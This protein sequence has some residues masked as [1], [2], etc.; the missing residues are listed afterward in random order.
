MKMNTMPLAT[1]AALALP[2]LTGCAGGLQ[3]NHAAD[4]LLR[5]ASYQTYGIVGHGVGQADADVRIEEAIHEA[6]TA[7]GFTH[8]KPGQVD[9]LVSVKVLTTMKAE[10]ALGT[11][12]LAAGD[13]FNDDGLMQQRLDKL[14]LLQL[15]DARSL[16]IVWVGWSQAAVTPEQL[17]ARATEAVSGLLNRVPA[18]I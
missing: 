14:V 9:L 11:G 4:P 15:Q 12:R 17:S 8:D 6:M 2:S 10:T 5:P 1:L 13:G 7:R 16:K 3:M 18:R